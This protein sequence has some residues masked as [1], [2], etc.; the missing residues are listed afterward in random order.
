MYPAIDD[1]DKR[2]GDKGGENERRHWLRHVGPGW[3]PP[4]LVF[5]F[6]QPFWAKLSACLLCPTRVELRDQIRTSLTPLIS[7]YLKSSRPWRLEAGLVISP[8]SS[9]M[10]LAVS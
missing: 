4:R 1:S 8:F 7:F 2:C 5:S 6:L 10:R 3:S 9:H